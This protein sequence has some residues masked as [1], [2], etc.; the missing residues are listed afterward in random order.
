MTTRLVL[1]GARE[2]EKTGKEGE[3]IHCWFYAGLDKDNKPMEFKSNT[4]DYK[5]YETTRYEEDKAKDFDL[6]GVYDSFK[7][8]I[9]FVEIEKNH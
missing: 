7:Q 4:P 8:K 9:K 3:Q 5:I 2:W 6:K 1:I